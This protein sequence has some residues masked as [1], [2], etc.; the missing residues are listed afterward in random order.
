MK[1]LTKYLLILF[2]ALIIH[3]C[4]DGGA[5]N[6]DTPLKTQD[7]IAI[8]QKIAKPLASEA[9]QAINQTNDQADRLSGSV[10]SA[11]TSHPEHPDLSNPLKLS[12]WAVSQWGAQVSQSGTARMSVRSATPR[13]TESEVLDCDVAGT[14]KLTIKASDAEELSPGDQLII[15][16][17]QCD[18]GDG[19]TINGSISF[20]FNEFQSEDNFNVTMLLDANVLT[21]NEVGVIKGDVTVIANKEN[22]VTTTTVTSDRFYIRKDDEGSLVE[23]LKTTLIENGTHYELDYDAEFTTDSIDGKV[24]IDT[25]PNFQGDTRKPYPDTG[26]MIITGANST[27]LQLNADTGNNAT[28]YLTVYDGSTTTSEEITWNELETL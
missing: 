12:R 9:Y 7:Y 18:Y 6:D 26:V 27:Y 25:D 3:G 19:S 14:A 4:G 1:Q 17:D 23:N 2:I 16:Y 21:N 22:G 10:K 13:A 11:N 8:D 20:T 28:L 15:E 5:G 24:T